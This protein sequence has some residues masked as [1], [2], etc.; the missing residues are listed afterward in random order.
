M[1]GYENLDLV[2]NYLYVVCLIILLVSFFFLYYY[3][4]RILDQFGKRNDNYEHE[5][6]YNQWLKTKTLVDH[7]KSNRLNN[8]KNESDFKSFI[9]VNKIKNYSGFCFFVSFIIYAIWTNL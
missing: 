7:Y 6:K 2:F 5:S 3:S 4:S 1:K 8:I 9:L